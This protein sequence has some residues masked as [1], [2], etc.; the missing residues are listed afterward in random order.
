MRLA[1]LLLALPLSAP[2]WAADD[3]EIDLLDDE[4]DLLEDSNEPDDEGRLEEGDVIEVQDDESE[5]DALD[6]EGARDDDLLEGEPTDESAAGDSALIYREALAELESL[7]TDEQVIGWEHYLER[8]PNT[9]FR[10]RIERHIDELMEE[11]YGERIGTGPAGPRDADTQEIPFAQGLLLENIN[12]RTSVQVGFEWGLP[13]YMNLY[14]GYE[15]QIWREFSVHG[16][17]RRRYTGWNIEAGVRYALVK[18]QRTQTL[19]TLIGDVHFNAEPAFLGV[20]PQIGIGK[21][22]ADKVHAQLQFGVDLETR[23]VTAPR[24]LYGANVTWLA[25]ENVALFAESSGN[26]KHMFFKEAEPFRFQV[27]SFGL[28]FYPSSS[29]IKHGDL[30]ANVGASAPYASAYWMY[31]FGSIMGQLNYYH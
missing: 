18:S 4:I 22:F 30:E 26:M 24:L 15:R 16:G 5:L 27:L 7:D 2:A 20:R 29:S 11:I 28:K 1:V 19:V 8:Y 25:S 23:D 9:E 14:G 6:L 12:P 3:D 13:N 21:I 10:P 17:V 31:H